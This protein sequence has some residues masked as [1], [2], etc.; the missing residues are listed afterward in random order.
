MAAAVCI[1]KTEAEDVCIN[2]ISLVNMK[3][4]VSLAKRKDYKAITS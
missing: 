1:Y 3:N 4:R 2:F